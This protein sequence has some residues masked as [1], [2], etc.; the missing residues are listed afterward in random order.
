L[1]SKPI[2]LQE[3]N[4][5]LYVN[6]RAGEDARDQIAVELADASGAALPGFSFAECD[7]INLSSVGAPVRWK[8]RTDLS[9]LAGR[10]VKVKIRIRAHNPARTG[11]VRF[12]EPQLYAFYFGR[13]TLW[14]HREQ[15]VFASGLERQH[16]SDPSLPVLRDLDLSAEGGAHVTLSTLRGHSAELLVTGR[17]PVRFASPSLESIRVDGREIAITNGAAVFETTAR[18]SVKVQLRGDTRN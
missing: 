5:R 8:N 7:P 14:L 12:Q 6:V 3:A 13:P 15:A 2:T 4:L 18:H 11:K 9:G 17:G 10:P 1:V 16:L